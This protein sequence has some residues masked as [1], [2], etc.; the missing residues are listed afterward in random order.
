M[1][2]NIISINILTTEA[3]NVGFKEQKSMKQIQSKV[4][5][6]NVE[7]KRRVSIGII[8]HDNEMDMLT[9]ISH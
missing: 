3:V 9:N 1:Y 2:L 7:A 6:Y 5:N 8:L 4:R